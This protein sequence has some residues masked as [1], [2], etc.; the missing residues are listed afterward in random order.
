M[1]EKQKS[2][3]NNTTHSR[4][5]VS[6]RKEETFAGP[7]PHPEI[8]EKYEK[9]YPGAAKIIF[10]EWDRQVKHR[11]EIEKSVIKTDNAKSILAVFVWF[12]Y[13]CFY[14]RGRCLHGFARETIIWGRAFSCWFGNVG[15]GFYHK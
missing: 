5:M 6:F 3:V 10:E 1:N 7:I 15:N 13:C 12:Y 11:H 9:I 4:Q 2:Q 8:I 14:Y